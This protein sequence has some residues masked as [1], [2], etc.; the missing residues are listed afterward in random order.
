MF[1]WL[2]FLLEI[3]WKKKQKKVKRK[4]KSPEYQWTID[5]L[6]KKVMLWLWLLQKLNPRVATNMIIIATIYVIWNVKIFFLLYFIVF[7]Y[8]IKILLIYK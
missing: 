5:D 4:K 3:F 6:K 1:R 7:L 2:V 8:I